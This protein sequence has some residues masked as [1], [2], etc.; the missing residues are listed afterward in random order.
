M[1]NDQFKAW[2]AER[3]SQQEQIDVIVSQTDRI[4]DLY[5][6]LVAIGGAIGHEEWLA[7]NMSNSNISD[8]DQLIWFLIGVIEATLDLAEAE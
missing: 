8:R 4:K 5:K 6:D 3:G 7:E 2:L 1:D